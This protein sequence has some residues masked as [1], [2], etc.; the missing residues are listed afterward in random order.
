M[1][2]IQLCL[3]L[4]FLIISLYVL[5][6]GSD[7]FVEGTKLLGSSLGMS[8][9]AVGILILAAGTSLPELASSIAA[10]LKDEPMIVIA[11]VVGSNITNILLIIGLLVVVAGEF[12]IKKSFV[13]TQLPIFAIAT[14]CLILVV[15]DGRVEKFEGVLLICVYVGYLWRLI[16]D[17]RKPD[18][19]TVDTNLHIP[20]QRKY[21]FY[22]LGGLCAVLIG[23]HY[24][25]EM[26]VLIAT[27]LSVP[28]G[29]ITIV[30]IAFGTSLPELSVA[31]HAYKKGDY[32]L[33]LGSIFGSNTFNILIVLSIPSLI[34]PLV[35]DAV[36]LN[37][38]LPIFVI[39]SVSL[40]LI[41]LSR[42]LLRWHGIVMLL[43]FMY[44][45]FM[46]AL[47]I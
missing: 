29:V 35:A 16:F 1:D 36:T 30:A 3:W 27:S 7:I 9:F 39:A 26:I 40:F 19:H 18:P 15:I 46:L 44:F 42:Q 13:R 10:V 20:F 25:V 8:S 38:G 37:V 11:N 43:F 14:A 17:A 32:E 41:G 45:L 2:W 21:I 22:I 28:L 31:F 34:L 4:S 12:N 23:A 5:I 47:Y 24:T 6:R 33:A